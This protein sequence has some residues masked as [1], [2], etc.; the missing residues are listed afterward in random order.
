MV[1]WNKDVKTII[2]KFFLQFRLVATSADTSE[3][4]GVWKR[5]GGELKKTELKL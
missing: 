2:I 4:G 3:K 5:C 1:L